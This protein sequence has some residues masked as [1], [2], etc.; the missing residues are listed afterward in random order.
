MSGGGGGGWA[1]R[2]GIA[3]VGVC[4]SRSASGRPTARTGGQTRVDANSPASSDTCVARVTTNS[5]EEPGH[6]DRAV[7]TEPRQHGQEQV[8]RDEVA[9]ESTIMTGGNRPVPPLACI[10]WARLW[11]FTRT[12]S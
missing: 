9:L 6:T 12:A 3:W 7:P 8:Q 2:R 4:N 5:K 1:R 10:A 11:I